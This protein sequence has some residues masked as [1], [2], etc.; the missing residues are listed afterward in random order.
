LAKRRREAA[1]PAPAVDQ[2][3]AERF[4]RENWEGLAAAAWRF[5]LRHGPGALIVEWAAVERW[6][7]DAS[8]PFAMHFTTATDDPAFNL[9]IARY[10]PQ[11]AIVIAF[12]DGVI[13][14]SAD[15]A[16]AG[17]SPLAVIRPGSGLAAMTM[18]AEP[19]PPAAH[20]ARGH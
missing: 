10:D 7:A 6:G 20:R 11:K 18:V 16:P 19:S 15:A 12:S 13:Q 14:G 17:A 1:P 4:V 2:S 5:Q 8:Q 9:V 3:L